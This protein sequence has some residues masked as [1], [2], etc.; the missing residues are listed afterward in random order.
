[1]S[2][3]SVVLVL[4]VFLLRR[5]GKIE[6]GREEGASERGRGG[7]R[8]R[9]REGG[10][11]EGRREGKREERR[12]ERGEREEGGKR[13]GRRERGSEGVGGNHKEVTST[14]TMLLSL[15][16]LHQC[17]HVHVHSFSHAY[18]QTCLPHYHYHLSC[19][20][21]WWGLQSESKMMTV[22]ADWSLITKPPEQK[23]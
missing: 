11:R 17:M 6:G 8:E 21:T 13:E 15:H 22:S 16:E 1:M 7:V 20:P 19:P 10:K 14:K 18:T 2:S 9:G 12:E 3:M 4:Q 23:R 5:E